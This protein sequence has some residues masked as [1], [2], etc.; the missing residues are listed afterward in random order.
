MLLLLL[1]TLLHRLRFTSR[2]QLEL[3]TFCAN[4]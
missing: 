2:C 4:G 1:L 3:V